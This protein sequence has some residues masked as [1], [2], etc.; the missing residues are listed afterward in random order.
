MASKVVVP[1]TPPP[2]EEDLEIYNPRVKYAIM[3]CIQGARQ[4]KEDYI[5]ERIRTQSLLDSYEMNSTITGINDDDLSPLYDVNQRLIERLLADSTLASPALPP[6]DPQDPPSSP[7]L[8]P[9]PPNQATSSYN[10]ANHLITALLRSHSPTPPPS[11]VY[12]LK[13][14]QTYSSPLPTVLIPGGGL[15]RLCFLLL[16]SPLPP[17]VVEVNESSIPFGVAL[18]ALLRSGL[19]Q[20]DDD[21][22][23]H[24]PGYARADTAEGKRKSSRILCAPAPV[25]AEPTAA[26]VQLGD[27]TALY[28]EG[29]RR[30]AFGHVLTSYFVDAAPNALEVVMTVKAALAGGGGGLTT[31]PC[32]GTGGAR[33]G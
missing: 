3:N 31:G 24:L 10:G 13:S 1:L 18:R 5:A 30:G 11:S 23:A 32:T 15:C 33:C 17:L 27:F 2:Y 14:Y 21:C 7:P 16:G 29:D 25:T 12:L 4:I 9:L 19:R 26:R 22:H 6:P 28:S 20:P 8:P